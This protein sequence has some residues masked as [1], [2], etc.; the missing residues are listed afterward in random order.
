M[1]TS[2]S[3][4]SAA[5][6]LSVAAAGINELNLD[7]TNNPS[8]GQ[9]LSAAASNR[10]TWIDLPSGGGTDT[11]DYATAGTFTL[12]GSDLSLQIR[13]TSGFTTFTVPMVTLPSGG[14]TGDIEGITTLATSGLAGGAVTGTP[15]LSLDLSGLAEANGQF[16]TSGTDRLYIENRDET[17]YQQQIS[18]FELQQ[19][20]MIATDTAHQ[21]PAEQDRFFVS[22]VSYQGGT[23]RYIRWDTLRTRF[24]NDATLDWADAVNEEDDFAPTRKTVAESLAAVTEPQLVISNDP[25]ADD[26]LSWNGT[27]MTWVTDDPDTGDAHELCYGR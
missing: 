23:P 12:S 14:G 19:A 8:T 21:N 26:V 25:S 13:G 20:L 27:A 4:T 24:T 15:S 16:I 3:L 7:G 17:P 18:I 5:G 1:A 22:D 11:N 2:T 6:V 10:F 9:V